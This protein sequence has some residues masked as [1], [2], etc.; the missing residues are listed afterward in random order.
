[1][2]YGTSK[3]SDNKLTPIR[4]VEEHNV[5]PSGPDQAHNQYD[6]AATSDR[7]SAIDSLNII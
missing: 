3:I 4:D 7:G 5:P 6:E 1:M 2:A